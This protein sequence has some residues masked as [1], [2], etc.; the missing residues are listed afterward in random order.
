MSNALDTIRQRLT[1]TEAEL[2]QAK[3]NVY[4]CDGAI[5]VLKHLLTELEALLPDPQDT[6]EK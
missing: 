4:R 3:A 2:E 5:I 1:S 6:S